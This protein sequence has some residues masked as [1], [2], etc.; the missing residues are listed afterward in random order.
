MIGFFWPKTKLKDS[1]TFKQ[2]L[3]DKIHEKSEVKVGPMTYKN[4]SV[5]DLLKILNALEASPGTVR[6]LRGRIK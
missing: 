4:H 5:D 1:Y 2:A 6:R 3:I